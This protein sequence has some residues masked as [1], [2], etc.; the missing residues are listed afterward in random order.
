M[1]EEYVGSLW[2]HFITQQAERQFPDAIVYLHEIRRQMGI[3]FRALGG[4]AGL[5]LEQATDTLVYARRTL[6]QKIAGTG[7]KTQYAWRDDET[8]RLPEAI[9]L[10]ADKQLN[11]NLYLWLTALSLVDVPKGKN[12]IAANQYRTR[13]IIAQWPGLR[14]LYQLLLQHYLP[15]RPELSRLSAAEAQQEIQIQQALT[16]PACPVQL[17]YAKRPPQ[18][19][20]LWLHPAP[21]K[22]DITSQPLADT[23][24]D[25][26]S[27]NSKTIENPQKK[28]QT[29][30]RTEMPDGKQ[31]LISFRLE[32]LWSWAEYS[33]LDR[34]TT[35]EDDDDLAQTAN[36]MDHIS[37]AND[38]SQSSSSKIK[39]DLDLP[40]SAYDDIVLSDGILL[41]EWHYKKQCLQKDH[42]RL[43]VMQPKD[44]Q[45]TALPAHLRA[46]AGKIR[47]QFEMIQPQRHWLRRQYDGSEVDIDAYV[48]LVSDKKRGYSQ[49]DAPVYRDQKQ[50]LRDLSCLLLADLSLSTDSYINDQQRVIDVIKDALFLFAEALDATGD[51]FAL[52]GFSSKN[53]NHVRF[54]EIK[55]FTQH[56]DD[57]I[58]GKIQAISP[59]YY[60]R[61]GAA[62]RYATQLLEQQPSSQKLLLLLTDGKPNDLDVYEGRYGLEDTRE[63]IIEAEKK[64][65]QP[66]CVTIDAEGG[67]YLSYL[68]GKNAYVVIKNAEELPKKLPLLYLRLTA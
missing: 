13:R 8:L 40:S 21:P 47:R 56:Y 55:T 39:L 65:L 14:P 42:C 53:R 5:Q 32:S 64:G 61:M 16:D 33:K 29:A 6:L 26:N 18:P 36:D 25:E 24:E 11:Y 35:D 19:V 46:K 62:I 31:G 34:T 41:D 44:A 57:Q 1:L 7:N 51:L 52:H 15:L 37:I 3:F 2:H 60:T 58:R 38:N 9:A 22:H 20:L 54:S 63:A 45:P 27:P 10:F 28:K 17:K 68:F 49:A 30:S 23:D 4:E 50:Q 43:L 12:W 67:D 59:G 66:F 48:H